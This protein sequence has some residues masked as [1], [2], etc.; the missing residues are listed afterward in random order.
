M[1]N[2][3]YATGELIPEGLTVGQAPI[4]QRPATKSWVGLGMRYSLVLVP[5]SA[6]VITVLLTSPAGVAVMLNDSESGVTEWKSSWLGLNVTPGS[7][8]VGTKL[9]SVVGGRE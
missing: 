6:Q 1:P 9:T 7:V 5:T 3:E 2:D 4:D 8:Q